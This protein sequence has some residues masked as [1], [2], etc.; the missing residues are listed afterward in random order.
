[1]QR[2]TIVKS[3]LAGTVFTLVSA[4]SVSAAL[5]GSVA[6]GA[7]TVAPGGAT[8]VTVAAEETTALAGD[9]ILILE[10]AP[11]GGA[12][13]SVSITLGT[14]SG[15]LGVCDQETATRISCLW[16]DNQQVTTAGL[17]AMATASGDAAGSFVITSTIS[18]IDPDNPNG[19]AI[20]DRAAGQATLLVQ[21]PTS[22]TVAPTTTVTGS[23][24]ALPDAG[25]SNAALLAA[26][27][28]I[29]LA[30][31]V[32]TVLLARRSTV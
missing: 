15:A 25:A 14:P 20:V 22:T 29:V 4:A 21:T 2:S 5:S 30:G 32:A 6:L 31:G 9:I 23:S 10:V 7:T 3:V 12:T 13:G 27:A 19:G 11:S 16:R 28:A 8:S 1:M 17:T 26:L 18:G 24:G